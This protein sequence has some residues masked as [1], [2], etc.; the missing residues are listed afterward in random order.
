MVLIT[1]F[2]SY[3]IVALIMF[4][5]GPV[6]FW[7]TAKKFGKFGE[8]QIKKHAL[9]WGAWFAANST[10][11]FVQSL[12]NGSFP[13]LSH[14]LE[15]SF[16]LSLIIHVAL[17]QLVFEAKLISVLKATIAYL[18]LFVL[19]FLVVSLAVIPFVFHEIVLGTSK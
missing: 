19:L 7:Y 1:A 8:Y 16:F 3:F 2:I 13:K 4:A 6:L 17:C 12:L 18:V 5:L 10:I 9:F 11:A 14:F 15:T